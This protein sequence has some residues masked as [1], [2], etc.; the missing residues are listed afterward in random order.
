[1]GSPKPFSISGCGFRKTNEIN[2]HKVGSIIARITCSCLSKSFIFRERGGMSDS[3]RLYWLHFHE[4][5]LPGRKL[6]RMFDATK[7]LRL[8][9]M[10]KMQKCRLTYL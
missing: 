8:W 10:R 5:L 2:D 9:K 3:R 7:R 4:L 6:R 1:M